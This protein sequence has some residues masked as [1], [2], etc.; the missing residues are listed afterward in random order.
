MTNL[1]TSPDSKAPIAYITKGKQRI[2]QNGNSV[3]LKDG[4]EFQIELFNP[5]QNKIK[6]EIRV[7]NK[8]IGPGIII[9]PGERVFLERY[10]SDSKKFL[11]STYIVDCNNS[12]VREAIKLNGDVTVKFYKEL[13]ATTSITYHNPYVNYNYYNGTTTPWTSGTFTCGGST[14]TTAGY[15]STWAS[16]N[17]LSEGT[18]EYSNKPFKQS[19]VETGR[20]EMGSDSK[21]SFTSDYTN[22]DQFPSWEILWKILPISQKHLT[23]NDLV[24][25]CGGCGRKKRNGENYCPS[26]GRKF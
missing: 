13:P 24:V 6:S 17:S 15:S 14:I 3:Y 21:Q 25:Y 19:S 20:V 12:Q 16:T 18:V 9:R 23:I 7:N 4:D 22:F 11:F 8:S 2:K 10:T 5:T 1:I 26:C